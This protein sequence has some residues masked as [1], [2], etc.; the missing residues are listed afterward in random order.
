MKKKMQLSFWCNGIYTFCESW[1]TFW[2]YLILY[3]CKKMFSRFVIT[4]FFL[5]SNELK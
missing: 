3:H 2:V 4:I 1:H 5:L